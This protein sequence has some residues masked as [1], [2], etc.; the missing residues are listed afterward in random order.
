[1]RTVGLGIQDFEQIRKNNQFYVDKTDF[2]RTWYKK[3]DSITL[4]TRPRRF[5]KTLTINMMN[6]FFSLDYAGRQDL[7]EN[8]AISQEEEMMKL[9]GT[10]PTIKVSFAG[11]KADSFREFLMELSGRISRLMRNYRF[12]AED[13][14]LSAEEKQVFED[15]S[16]VV[17]DVPDSQLQ[18][19][20]YERFIY[21]L[22]HSIQYLSGWLYRIHRKKVYVLMDEYD[23]PIQSAY[24][25]HYYPEAM[26]VMRALFSESFKEN[27]YLDRALITGITRIAKE[28]MFSDMNNLVSYS[29][30]SGGYDSYFGFTRDEMNAILSEYDLLDQLDLVKDWYDG[31]TIGQEKEIYNPWSVINY[32]SRRP[33]PP[34]AYWAQ[35]GGFG[36]ADHLIRHGDPELHEK[37]QELVTEG[38]I[39]TE[40]S[41]DLI[42]PDLDNDDR[43]V[44]SLLVAAGYLKPLKTADP[45][46]SRD[47]FDELFINSGLAPTQIT[48]TNRD[49]NIS[50]LEMSR[51]WFQ[52]GS[53]NHMHRFSEALL[54][55]DVNEMNRQ[56]QQIVLMAVSSFDSGVKPSKGEIQPENYFHGL[57]TGL[58]FDLY[59]RFSLTSN[60]ESGFGRYDICLEPLDKRNYKTPYI[61]EL[62]IFSEKEGD[63]DLL[64]TARRALRQISDKRYDYDL[65]AKGYLPEEIHRYGM[66]FRGKEVMIS[67]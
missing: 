35:S 54:N 4:I 65:L 57:T 9:Q 11:I 52:N 50:F 6:C 5:G 34:K 42:F 7:F 30:L 17:P 53:V 3:N 64:D 63:K 33:D 16:R 1:M 55:D 62:K 48:V 13:D 66:G 28:S 49:A 22:T 20:D 18:R 8:L 12:L 36:L 61:L 58:L 14:A 2:I 39:C 60:R 23:T 31:Y 32:L 38:R 19:K 40:L 26:K 27:E 24:L 21:Q 29:V 59:G 56:M 10:I 44:W 25:S 47:F 51:R 37:L 67:D 43:A 46:S 45:A 41:E 15:L